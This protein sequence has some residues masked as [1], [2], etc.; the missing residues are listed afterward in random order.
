MDRRA[1]LIGASA[2]LAVRPSFADECDCPLPRPTVDLDFIA[3]K[4]IGVSTTVIKG[5]LLNLT[6]GP[7]GVYVGVEDSLSVAATFFNAREGTLIVDA[8]APNGTTGPGINATVASF[9][10]DHSANTANIIVA[11]S[12]Q[13]R[14]HV[15]T[16]AS[17]NFF[18]SLVT[19][20]AGGARKK[21]AVSYSKNHF[22]GGLSSDG[23]STLD[24]SYV[25]WSNDVVDK[26]Y[27]GQH[28]G[29]NYPWCSW[30]HRVTYYNWQLDDDLI[31]Q[32][33]AP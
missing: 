17:P 28:K 8:T 22:F 33:I 19:P 29:G 24:G 32:L 1:F 10:G 3:G 13:I 16:Q 18:N 15:S 31:K 20:W 23:F 9:M 27:I 11:S 30:I 14:T 5:Q 2:A 25:L 4:Y 6:T 7:L 26:L 12:Q 21:A